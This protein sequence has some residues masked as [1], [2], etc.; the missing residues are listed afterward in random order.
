MMA[1]LAVS[2]SPSS[3][4]ALHAPISF[5]IINNNH[6]TKKAYHSSVLPSSPAHVNNGINGTH[7]DVTNIDKL[8]STQAEVLPRTIHFH[9]AKNERN[10]KPAEQHLSSMSASTSTSTSTSA[11]GAYKQPIVI[12]I[13]ATN[14]DAMNS[15]GHSDHHHSNSS[16]VTF[17]HDAS[18]GHDIHTPIKPVK[19]LITPT[20]ITNDTNT[21]SSTPATAA[22]ITSHSTSQTE[23]NSNFTHCEWNYPCHCHDT[24]FT[25][26]CIC[27]CIY[28]YYS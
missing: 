13:N 9:T 23:T 28:I 11:A 27:I 16:S 22:P 3:S 4:P 7:D 19:K 15:N 18:N 26:C 6:W 24:T 14:P 8:L 17:H 2:P 20:L 1:T 5:S 25:C 21:P 10:A 12:S